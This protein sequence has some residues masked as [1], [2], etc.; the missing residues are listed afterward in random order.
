[1]P[2][3]LLDIPDALWKRVEARIRRDGHDLPTIVLRA[4]TR[5]ARSGDAQDTGKAGGEA[6][7]RNL[8]E[9]DRKAIAQKAAAARW[10][11]R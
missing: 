10:G 4:L 3:F 5:Y 2:S 7:A 1:M 11:K 9:S 6:R 8:T